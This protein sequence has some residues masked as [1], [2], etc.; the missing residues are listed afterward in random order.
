M[1]V[2]Y[3]ASPILIMGH[4]PV[5]RPGPGD[6]TESSFWHCTE[7]LRRIGLVSVDFSSP[8]TGFEVRSLESTTHQPYGYCNM[9]SV[10]QHSS[11]KLYVSMHQRS[12]ASNCGKVFNSLNVWKVG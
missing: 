11:L 1:Q 9:M 5:A 2:R 6:R 12:R 7:T 10:G 3:L 8:Q 4:E